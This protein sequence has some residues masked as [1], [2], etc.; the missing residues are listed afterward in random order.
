MIAIQ[1]K[2]DYIY[3]YIYILKGLLH[4]QDFHNKC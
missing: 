2:K 3:I 4:P 1:Q